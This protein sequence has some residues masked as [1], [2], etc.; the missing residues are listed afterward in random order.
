[1][2]KAIANNGKRNDRLL[3]I[4]SHEGPSHVSKSLLL[5]RMGSPP[6]TRR[7]CPRERPR[8]R[9]A[10]R[11]QQL[12]PSDGDCHMPL[13]CKVRRGND[14]TSRACSLY[15]Q[16]GPDAGCSPLSSASGFR[17]GKAQNEARGEK[18]KYHR[19]QVT[20]A[21]AGALPADCH[22]HERAQSCLNRTHLPFFVI[23][24]AARKAHASPPTRA[25]MR[26]EADRG[27]HQ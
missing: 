5:Q 26:L 17:S 11:G 15:V 23:G 13:P 8:R 25:V 19:P 1:M 10:E 16:G 6:L 4:D 22:A 7:A 27:E 14:T 24:S 18:A 3:G 9:T 21:A 12:P 20:P 2:A